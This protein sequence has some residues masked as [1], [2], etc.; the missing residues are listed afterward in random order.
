MALDPA[1][2]TRAILLATGRAI[3]ADQAAALTRVLDQRGEV[4]PWLAMRAGAFAQEPAVTAALASQ[5]ARVARPRTPRRSALHSATAIAEAQRLSDEAIRQIVAENVERARLG[6][7]AN[8]LAQRVNEAVAG[9]PGYDF[10][11]HVGRVPPPEDL[12]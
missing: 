8:G 5:A 6:E 9:L 7:E 4:L 1:W 10:A 12:E 2:L 3:P 11:R